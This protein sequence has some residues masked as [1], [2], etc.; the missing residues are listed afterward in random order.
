M[1]HG[2][3]ARPPYDLARPVW[4]WGRANLQWVE[5]HLAK[6]G[7][8]WKDLDPWRLFAFIYVLM[9]E[10]WG[11]R[12]ALDEALIQNAKKRKEPRDRPASKVKGLSREQA[13]KMARD[14]DDYDGSI[15]GGRLRQD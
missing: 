1:A 2:G 6:T 10:E 12:V 14:L 9:A 7:Q 3:D 8:S 4:Q 11:G 15:V 5:G 13:E